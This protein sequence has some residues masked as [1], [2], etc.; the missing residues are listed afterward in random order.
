MH[1][2]KLSWSLINIAFTKYNLDFLYQIK[3]DHYLVKNL[4]YILLSLSIHVHQGKSTFKEYERTRRQKEIQAD[5]TPFCQAFF[6]L[7]ILIF[8]LVFILAWFREDNQLI[9]WSQYI[10]ICNIMKCSNFSNPC[11]MPCVK[12][13]NYN[14][15]K[16]L[17]NVEFGVTDKVVR[18]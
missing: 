1:V 7:P 18:L 3:I 2:E 14:Q 13:R 4:F 15:L 12:S 11:W 16:E 9:I 6:L 8:W 10:A 5:W 17:S